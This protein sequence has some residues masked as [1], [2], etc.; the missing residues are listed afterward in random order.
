MTTARRLLPVALGLLGCAHA[1][2][3]ASSSGILRL[4]A[5]GDLQIGARSRAEAV[6]AI[7]SVLPGDLRFA[8]LEG[9]FTARGAESDDATPPR[10][11][12]APDDA[13]WLSGR[14]DVLSVANNHILDQG[15]DGLR[16]TLSALARAGIDAA[17]ES[18]SL[19]LLRHGVRVVIRAQDLS[20]GWTE[21]MREFLVLQ[22][23]SLR[24]QGIV[25]LS[26][27]WGTAGSFLPTLAQR[28]LAHALI[29]AGASVVLGHGPHTLQGVERY[30]GGVVAYSLGNLAFACSCSTERDAM[31]LRVDLDATGRLDSVVALPLRAG[32]F[33]APQFT[34]DRDVVTL[35]ETLSRDLGTRAEVTA[36]TIRMLP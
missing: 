4:V 5:A 20:E 2:P 17:T 35:I 22:T 30:D 3:D 18:H 19:A 21:E 28:E 8:N 16:D 6:K 15:S 25:V 32:L 11:A 13:S 36:G 34:S 27:H 14:V 1:P 7:S 31:V 10:F 26:L 24:K 12:A 33:D 23:R 9:P 29:D